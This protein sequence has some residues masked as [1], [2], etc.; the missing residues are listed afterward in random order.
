MNPIIDPS[1]EFTEIEHAERQLQSDLRSLRN[2]IN[3]SSSNESGVKALAKLKEMSDNKIHGAMHLLGYFLW[4]GDTIEQNVDEAFSLISEAANSGHSPAMVTL[5]AMY[6]SGAG[7]DKN[8]DL[9]CY[10]YKKREEC[11]SKLFAFNDVLLTRVGLNEHEFRWEFVIEINGVRYEA[12]KTLL[13]RHNDWLLAS[14]NRVIDKQLAMLERKPNCLG[15]G[16]NSLPYKMG[17]SQ[18]ILAG[19]GS[20]S[21]VGWKRGWTNEEV[22]V[23]LSDFESQHVGN[24]SFGEITT[25]KIIENGYESN[26]TPEDA[27]AVRNAYKNRGRPAYTK[28]FR[29]LL[30]KIKPISKHNK[31]DKL[32]ELHI[33]GSGLGSYVKLKYRDGDELYSVFNE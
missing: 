28:F 10:W 11:W 33:G 15:V 22:W 26:L 3:D 31:N 20:I 18:L 8:F 27:E 14:K 1:S 9:A 16:K 21:Q 5:G 19:E 6:L 32:L 7:C 4:A 30:E 2:A 24:T 23:E 12:S 17:G 25:F 29:K 13:E